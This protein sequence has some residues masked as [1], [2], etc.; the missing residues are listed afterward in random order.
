M[1][2]LAGDATALATLVRDG[3]T[4]A[5]TIG[6]APEVP[7][8]RKVTSVAVMADPNPATLA[9]LAGQVAAGALRVPVTAV[10]E[11]EQADKAFA[12][13]PTDATS[14]A[15][16]AETQAERA[17]YALAMRGT[18][19]RRRMTEAEIKAIVDKWPCGR[20]RLAARCSPRERRSRTGSWRQRS[21]SDRAADQYRATIGMRP[22]GCPVT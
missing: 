16:I 18:A 11:L 3:G 7:E 20:G 4:I 8:G 10:Y 9:Q 21:G 17:S 19:T 22:A 14:S 5:S 1:A 13:L 15:W 6:F 12:A 2:H